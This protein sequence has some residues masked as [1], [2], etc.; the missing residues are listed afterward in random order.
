MMFRVKKKENIELEELLFGVKVLLK[1]IFLPDFVIVCSCS[2]ESNIVVST[3][4]PLL[5]HTL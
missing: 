4:E 5:M 1:I 3:Y 2:I